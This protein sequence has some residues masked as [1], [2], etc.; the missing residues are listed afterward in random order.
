MINL[1]IKILL[2]VLLAIFQVTIMPL[3][4]VKGV[5]PNI[6]F[7]F[8]VILALL[9][10]DDDALLVAG[11]GGLLLDISGTR[12]FGTYTIFFLLLIF[13]IK[14]INRKIFSETSLFSILIFFLSSYLIF[15]LYLHL[16]I[17]R[18][19]GVNLVYEL[20]YGL[21]LTYLIYW[22]FRSFYENKSIIKINN[23]E[24]FRSI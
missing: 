4:S 12:F 24:H 13:A 16:I 1:I 3:L 11:I 17:Y 14:Y 15:N 9:N 7:I 6:V 20:F 10:F 21:I 8:I 18:L 5:Y 22:V 19:P 23:N 2:I